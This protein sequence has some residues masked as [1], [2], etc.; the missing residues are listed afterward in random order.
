V[1]VILERIFLRLAPPAAG[2]L[3]LVTLWAVFFW[4]PTD[5]GLGL[6]QR[7]FYYHVPSAT[8]S[9]LG[10]AAGGVASALFLKTRRS[11]WDHAAHAAIGVAMTF[12]TIVLLTGSIWARTAWGTW[13]TWD[14]RL[15][16]FLVL[17]ALFASYSL[18]RG[19]TR[20]SELGPRYAAVLAVV[21]AL[22]IPLVMMA[23]RLWRT[24]HPQV[25]RNPQGGIQDPAMRATLGL[26]MIAFFVLFAWLWA[27][28]VRV[29]RLD[30]RVE[31]LT[32]DVA[33]G[34][35]AR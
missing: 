32:A 35:P 14:A 7:I 11:D 24:I 23:T 21:G 15:T 33:E 31:L 30:E 5:A 9:F 2:A 22:N 27:L 19:F 28:R 12:A 10:F 34:R 6:S 25:I 8:T 1:V 20:G 17:W 18:L 16:T 3:F 4:V 29:L 13:W 26:C